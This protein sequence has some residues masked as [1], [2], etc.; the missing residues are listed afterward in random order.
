MT[1]LSGSNYTEAEIRL[2]ADA[3]AAK[4]LIE[5]KASD[6]E[7][8]MDGRK[9]LQDLGLQDALEEACQ[10]AVGK[11]LTRIGAPDP[12]GPSALLRLQAAE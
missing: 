8:L 5:Q 1:P 9:T 10:K 4:L 7:A 11:P 6:V 3:L 2:A 12:S